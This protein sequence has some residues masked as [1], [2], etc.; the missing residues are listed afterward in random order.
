MTVGPSPPTMSVNA[1]FK[2][3]EKI[4]FEIVDGLQGLADDIDYGKAKTYSL[5]K[6]I[7]AL[8]EKLGIQEHGLDTPD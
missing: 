3:L 4:L 8:E 2:D 5:Q 6:R 7:A 1:R